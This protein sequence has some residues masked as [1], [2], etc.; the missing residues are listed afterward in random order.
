[1][2]AWLITGCSSGFGQRLALAAA[3][4][5]D[6]VIAMARNIETIAHMAEV[7]SSTK[8]KDY[9]LGDLAT[10]LWVAR[11]AGVLISSAA[12]RHLDNTFVLEH[13]GEF[14]ALFA[15]ADLMTDAEPIIAGRAEIVAAARGTL[16][17][18]EPD[19]APGAHCDA[20]F[21]CEF[22]S[23]CH[24]MLPPGPEWP[25][26]V[27]PHGGGKRWLERGID[28]LFAVE[29]GALTNATQ[30]RVHRATVS[31]QTYHD[32][33]GARAAMARWAFPR[34]WL[35]FETIGFAVPRWVGTRP[36]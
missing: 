16:A 24:R 9:H 35:D 19:V 5:G 12:I 32:V 2:K 8:A 17:G 29:P 27:L 34:T 20:P 14:D 36:Y 31:G 23:H 21:P 3:R 25:V 15:D 30:V 13:E 7:K 10:Q 1:M 33:D 4:R 6:R 11:H 22:A 18:A 26:T 28:D